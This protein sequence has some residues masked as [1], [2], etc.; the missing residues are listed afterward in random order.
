MASCPFCHAPVDDKLA[1]FGGHCPKCFIEIPGEETPT[2]PG[3]QAKAAAEAA[4]T[5]KSR[6]RLIVGGVV[7]AVFLFCG[8]FVSYTVYKTRQEQMALADAEVEFFMEPVNLPEAQVA[9]A[10]GGSPSNGTT[11][12]RNPG[13]RR[14]ANTEVGTSSGSS[15]GPVRLDFRNDA[16]AMESTPS[17]FQEEVATLQPKIEIGG[18]STNLVLKRPSVKPV[19]LSDPEEIKKQVGGA[20]SKYR[21]QVTAC[22]NLRLKETP[23]LKGTWQIR[24]TIM[25]TGSTSNVAVIPMGT[26]DPKLESC[27]SQKAS[28]WTFPA[29]EAPQ[30]IEVPYKLGTS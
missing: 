26:N 22:Y 1:R 12:P 6:T 15:G 11:A 13:T 17:G 30:T 19:G 25:T 27:M 3:A 9:Q 28:S 4:Q 8:A 18:D 10:S 29:L 20:L 21:A 5:S 7:G 23:T 16:S 2:D 14:P 24:M